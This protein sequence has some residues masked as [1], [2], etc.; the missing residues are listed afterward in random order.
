[1]WIYYLSSLSLTQKLG[2]DERYNIRIR[3][4]S[5]LHC[6]HGAVFIPCRFI[7]GITANCLAPLCA[8]PSRGYSVEPEVLMSFR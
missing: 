8:G 4:Y 7:E 2:R 5:R 6:R 1:M 3:A